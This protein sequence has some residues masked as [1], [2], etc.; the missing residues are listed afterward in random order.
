MPILLKPQGGA[1]S[2]TVRV[3]PEG[4][5]R[6]GPLAEW[7]AIP[8]LLDDA[9]N[10]TA[11]EAARTTIQQGSRTREEFNQDAYFTAL[12]G[13]HLKGW[14]LLV[15]PD[16]PFD[17]ARMTLADGQTWWQF[18]PATVA[19]LSET[20]RLWLAN[21]ILARGGIIPTASLNVKTDSGQVLDFRGA[22]AG[23]GTGETD[24]VPDSLGNP[25]VQETGG[26]DSP[27]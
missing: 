10:K 11:R 15:P 3:T 7:F 20:V 5:E 2:E 19:A 23:L 21:E 8:R 16:E 17:P 13:S 9:A 1:P 6:E 24:Q 18:L 4:L 12:I 27:A 25:L 26:G 14:R 22:D